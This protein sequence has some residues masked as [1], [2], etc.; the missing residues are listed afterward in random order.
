MSDSNE[1]S[2]VCPQFSA[3]NQERKLEKH[4]DK[5]DGVFNVGNP[6]FTC[7]NGISHEIPSPVLPEDCLPA[8]A[9]QPIDIFYRTT[10]S[11]YGSL[12]PTCYS[13]PS[14]YYPMSQKFSQ[15]LGVCGMPRN[16]SLNCASDK[17]RVPLLWV[18]LGQVLWRGEV[19]NA[20]SVHLKNSSLK[21]K[22]FSLK[23]LSRP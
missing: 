2:A 1:Q 3:T 6:V 10:S 15:H 12:P 9:C 18:S 17:S 19:L 20:S 13:V 23:I 5:F 8:Y 14:T 22:T 7:G 4:L 16:H 11:E 21:Y